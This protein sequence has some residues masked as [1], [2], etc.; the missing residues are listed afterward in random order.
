VSSKGKRD[1]K[2]IGYEREHGHGFDTPW[3]S[4]VGGSG[5]MDTKA[6]LERMG[7][8]VGDR[9]GERTKGLS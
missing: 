5:S 9:I 2:T 1:R 3:H 4:K 6:A 7:K 8:P